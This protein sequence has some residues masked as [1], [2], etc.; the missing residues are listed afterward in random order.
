[1]GRRTGRRARAAGNGRLWP[2]RPAGEAFWYA[3][4][5]RAGGT[6]PAWAARGYEIVSPADSGGIALSPFVPS[7][8]TADETVVPV[9]TAS[10]D[11]NPVVLT[12]ASNPVPGYPSN[13]SFDTFLSSRTASGWSVAYTSPGAGIGPSYL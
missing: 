10:T 3:A 2:G 5:A 1:M 9:L 13:G 12:S 8:P 6:A 11:G 7:A 4:A